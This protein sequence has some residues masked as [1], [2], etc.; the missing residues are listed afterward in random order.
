MSDMLQ[1]I[2]ILERSMLTHQFSLRLKYV[3]AYTL[4]MVER[5]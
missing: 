3:Y 5:R 4:G 1:L 2:I